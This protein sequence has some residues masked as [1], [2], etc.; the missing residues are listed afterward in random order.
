MISTVSN[1]NQRTLIFKYIVQHLFI[2]SLSKTPNYGKFKT[3][4]TA[5][6]RKTIT[7]RYVQPRM[8]STYTWSSQL[9]TPH[10]MIVCGDTHGQQTYF[11]PMTV[12]ELSTLYIKP[13]PFQFLC[14]CS[15]NFPAYLLIMHIKYT[16]YLNIQEG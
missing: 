10:T 6:S 11:L 12:V 3:V 8:Y 1:G 16:T 13:R 2:F 7:P 14:G 9:E 5:A 4:R 15:D